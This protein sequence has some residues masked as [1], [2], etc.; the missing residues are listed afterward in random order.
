MIKRLLKRH[1][2]EDKKPTESSQEETQLI[3][4]IGEA[5]AG[6]TTILHRLRTGEFYASSTRTL[7][8][9]V[10]AFEYRGVKFQA[11][12]L[13]GQDSFHMIWGDYLRLSSAV[14]FVIDC[15][16]PE[17]F[18]SSKAALYNALPNIPSNAILLIAA[19]KADISGVNPYV[20]LLKNFDLYDIQQKGQF[21]AINIFHMSAKSGS[22]FYQAF[23]WL[24]ETLTGEI[25][26]PNVNIHNIC[27]YQT[28]TGLLIGSSAQTQGQSHYDPVL[29]TGMFSAVNTFAE[30][31]M[32]AGVR[33]IL[34][35]R[36]EGQSEVSE[37]YKL[38]RVEESDISVILIVDETNSMRRSVQIGK[39]LLLWTRLR[40]PDIEKASLIEQIDEQEIISYL[41]MKYPD[42]IATV[43]T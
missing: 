14:V 37:N 31:S 27:I 11:F 43:I 30:A 1:K 40:I 38:V 15:S 3:T 19:N 8:L 13:G 17:N 10:D 16:N 7:G 41:T 18:Q 4:F 39:D 21:R 24:I 32:G 29:L 28:D 26:L 5:F 22:N 42:D 6:K 35:K 9:N 23:D 12:D 20:A 36:S 2:K 25:I 33:E 34:M